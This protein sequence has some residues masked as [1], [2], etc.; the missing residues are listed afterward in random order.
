MG[1]SEVEKAGH[2][3]HLGRAWAT[4]RNSRFG[5]I[6]EYCLFEN[7]SRQSSTIQRIAELLKLILWS[8]KQLN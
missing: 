7:Q 1:I 3:Q 6:S 2:W 8:E 5:S 4:L